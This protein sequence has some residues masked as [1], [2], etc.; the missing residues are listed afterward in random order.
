[1]TDNINNKDSLYAF[2]RFVISLGVLFGLSIADLNSSESVPN[3]VYLL[4][5]GLNGVDAYKLYREIQK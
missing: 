5:G 4:V 1:M 2:F 3:I